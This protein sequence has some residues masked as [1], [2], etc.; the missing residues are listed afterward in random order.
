MG[1]VDESFNRCINE[2]HRFAECFNLAVGKELI[3]PEGLSDMERVVTGRKGYKKENDCMKQYR[4]R[5]V[6]AIVGIES[7]NKIYIPMA[8]RNYIYEALR[9]DEQL[10]AIRNGHRK[11][12]DI[13]N[14]E[15]IAGF[16]EADRLLPVIMVCVYFGEEPWTAPTRLHDL[17]DFQGIPE[18]EREMFQGLVNDYQLKILDVRHMSEKQLKKMKTD[19]RYLFG[20]I[21]ASNNKETFYSYLEENQAELSCLDE[22]LYCAMTAITNT[23]DWI[24]HIMATKKGGCV[25]MCKAVDD[26]RK[27]LLETGKTE[28]KIEG[29][30]A[31]IR[32]CQD[33]DMTMQTVKNQ[34]MKQFQL[35]NDAAEKY[36][37]RF[38]E[39]VM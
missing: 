13:Q 15:Y 23:W 19:L 17:L 21:Q 39:K 24:E 5:V 6:C 11:N 28:G 9:Y 18:E 26:W 20:M 35:N 32:A 34:L 12:R 37:Q 16:S 27:E 29:I 10:T 33:L 2:C 38:W 25:N 30:Q 36:I 8:A 4:N 14:A 22:D 7:Q 3:L 31:F 1:E